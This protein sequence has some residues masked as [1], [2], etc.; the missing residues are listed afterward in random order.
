VVGVDVFGVEVFGEEIHDPVLRA[1]EPGDEVGF[2]GAGDVGD[3]LDGFFARSEGAA[4][5]LKSRALE[6]ARPLQ[7][8]PD[9]LGPTARRY[10]RHLRHLRHLRAL[11]GVAVVVSVRADIP[12]TVITCVP[13]L[14]SA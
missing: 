14:A 5:Q 1:A 10:R 11:A 8:L 6:C 2:E 3:L 13:T 4:V 9:Y 7:C 12:A